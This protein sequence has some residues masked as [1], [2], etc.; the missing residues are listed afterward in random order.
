MALS[1]ASAL[2]GLSSRNWKWLTG[3]VRDPL[4]AISGMFYCYLY[5]NRTPSSVI[6]N[7]TVFVCGNV[8]DEWEIEHYSQ[9][10]GFSCL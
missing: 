1:G 7:L 5:I 4:A 3:G 10:T 2:P 8:K 6:S 9:D